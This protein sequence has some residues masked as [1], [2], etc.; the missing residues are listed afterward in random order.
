MASASSQNR[1]FTLIELLLVV[2]ILAILMAIAV[3]TYLSQQ[4][5]AKDQSAKQTLAYAYRVA[6]GLDSSLRSAASA[7]RLSLRSSLRRRPQS[8]VSRS[9]AETAAS[10]CPTRL[11]S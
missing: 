4:K 10:Q 3:P 8:P 1:G 11:S 5:K 6:R 2:I 9:Q 7:S